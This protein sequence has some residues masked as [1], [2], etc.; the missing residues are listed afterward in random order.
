MSTS[1]IARDNVAQSTNR[2]TQRI[3]RLT[4]LCAAATRTWVVRTRAYP[5]DGA[6]KMKWICSINGE[7][8]TSETSQG[9][10]RAEER[11]LSC[12]LL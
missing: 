9:E 10:K 11:W 2:D 7:G 3:F 6:S 5:L 4:A 1:S 8:G 12:L